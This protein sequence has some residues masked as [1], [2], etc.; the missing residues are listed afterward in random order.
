MKTPVEKN[1][2]EVISKKKNVLK[3][4]IFVLLL[5][6]I[7]FYSYIRFLEPNLLFVEEYAIIDNQLPSTF[8]GIK[9]VQFSDVLYGTSVNEKKL[10]EVV[11]KI[12]T[13]QPD[14]V[15]FTGD[16]FNSNLR[17]NNE[18]KDKIKEI[19]GKIIAT[20]KKYAVLGDN[21]Y[22][23]K[24]SFHDIMESSGFVILNNSSDL[25][26]YKG[27]E[28]LMFIGTNSLLEKEFDMESAIKTSEDIT[29]Y[30]KIWLHHEPIILDEFS[31]TSIKPNL[32]FSGHTL[33]GL[34]TLP[35]DSTLLNQEGVS[36]YKGN[37]Y[38]K[39]NMKMYISGGLGT[40]KYNV[41]FLNPPSISLYRLYQY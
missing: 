35:F 34:V 38:N 25:F 13:L 12:N 10:E 29:N 33:N 39:N 30:Y 18:D 27:N 41:R 26:Y 23:D 36:L 31:N 20:Y 22:F 17:L 3:K 6:I 37:T 8:H 16:L 21:D 2:E 40:Y 5:F 1:K 28:P 11:T 15:I 9:I 14:I 4:V 7:L 32:I 24:S 19:L